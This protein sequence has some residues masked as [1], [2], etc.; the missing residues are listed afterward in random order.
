LGAFPPWRARGR[1]RSGRFWL[2]DRQ[3]GHCVGQSLARH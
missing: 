1:L 3:S 2:N